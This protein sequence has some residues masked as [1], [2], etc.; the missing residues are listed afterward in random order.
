MES[1]YEILEAII[2]FVAGDEAGGASEAVSRYLASPRVHDLAGVVEVAGPSGAKRQALASSQ[3]LQLR[4]VGQVL[5]PRTAR[6][7]AALSLS[8]I[9]I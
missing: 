9:H 1:N 7:V 3:P 2:A 6:L 8:L 4:G 5:Q